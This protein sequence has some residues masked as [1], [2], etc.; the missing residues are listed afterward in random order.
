MDIK[1]N[2]TN[3]PW[4]PLDDD[5]LGRLHRAA[6][7]TVPPH[8]MARAI[9]RALRSHN[10]PVAAPATNVFMLRRFRLPLALAASV[11]A[12]V[13]VWNIERTA[14]QQPAPYASGTA[15]ERAGDELGKISKLIE[16]K[17][18]PGL[19]CWIRFDIHFQVL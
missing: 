9:E 8:I 15:D 4:P 1:P 17:R 11:L 5:G 6:A 18:R 14:K 10:K 13:L 3:E 12:G 16:Q 2:P 7:E 19:I